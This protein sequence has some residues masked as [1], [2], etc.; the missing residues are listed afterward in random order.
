MNTLKFGNGEWYGKKD[1]ILAYNDENNNYKPLPFDFSRASSAT[2][3]NKDGLIETVG[4]GEPRIDFKDNTKGALLLEPSRTN[5]ITYSEDFSQWSALSGVVVTDN[6]AIS[7]NGTQNASKLVFDGTTNGIIERSV[8][9]SGTKTQSVYLKTES[10]TQNVSI[11]VGSADLT[12]F[13]ITDQWVRYTHTG[14]GNYPRI[15]CND[16]AT[17]YAWGAQ[18]EQG[19]YATSYIPNYGTA[20]GVTR[21]AE[22]ATGSGDAST[23]NSSQGV[24]MAEISALESGGVNRY[25]SLSDNTTSNRIQLILS[26]SNANRISVNGTGLTSIDYDS[27]NQTDMNKVA[28]KY[29]S[30]GIKL[31]VNGIEVGSNND[32]A[33]WPS[34]TLTTLDFALWNQSSVP[35]YGNTKQVRYY[36]SALTD[37]E[38]ETLTSWVSFTD[39]AEGQLY[40][41]E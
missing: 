26:G 16:A 17:I 28:F 1:T 35:F 22:T 21:S 7:P 24:L 8:T 6:F 27:Y 31:F 30:S 32:D 39:M 2:R 20:L 41:I 14:T 13:T 18:V 19:S 11:G 23:F 5:L 4:G 10:G 12:E 38:L 15:L 9:A 37:S 25:I 3:V 40:T 36:D 33:T 34:G 29:S